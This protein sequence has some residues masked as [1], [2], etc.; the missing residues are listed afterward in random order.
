MRL[1]TL[2]IFI[3]GKK[4]QSDS[5]KRM[6]QIII[7]ALQDKKGRNIADVDLSVI[8]DTICNHMIICTGG[9]PAQLNALASSVDDKVRSELHIH[10]LAVDGMHYAHWVAM[11]YADVMVH[12][13]LEEERDFYDIEHL[14]ADA[15]LAFIPDLD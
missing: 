5:T 9:S 10:P 11:D 4:M 1:F 7:D 6:V 12:I 3:D 2:Y 8:P 13:F 14:W 15:E